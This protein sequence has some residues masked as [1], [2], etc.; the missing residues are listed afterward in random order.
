MIQIGLF[1]YGCVGRGLYKALQQTPQLNATI[2]KIVVKNKLKPRDINH[3]LFAYDKE[4]ILNDREINLVIELIDDADGAFKILTVALQNGKPVISANKKMLANHLEEIL[5]L[6]KKYNL[7][8]LYEAAVAGSIPII[9]SIEEYYNIDTI[10]HINGILNGTTNYIL[11]QCFKE[12]KT[13]ETALKEAQ[14]KGFAE[15]NPTMDIEAFDPTFK[16]IL[17]LAH[18]FGVVVKPEDVLNFG[19]TQLT[20]FDIQFAKE[21]KQTIKLIAQAYQTDKGIAA[22]VLP[23]F[24][25]EQHPL[26]N[27]H[28]E[29]NAVEINGSFNDN[30]LLKGKGA[31]GFPT[32]AAVLADIF[33][34][35]NQYRYPYLKQQLKPVNF[36]N[37]DHLLKI[38]VRYATDEQFEAFHFHQILAR[39]DGNAYR[40]A[41]GYITIKQLI[42]AKLNQGKGAFVAEIEETPIQINS[43]VK[44]PIKNKLPA[45]ESIH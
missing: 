26:Y 20:L 33:A 4:E 23:K 12:A 41:I 35:S 5:L 17:L 3:E 18:A 24:I 39:Y 15:S 11:T 30:Q 9:R 38:Y 16:L 6:Q 21:K 10:T 44:I 29:F 1:G 27:I 32:A 40:Y 7:P 8:V 13:F 45:V 34:L 22:Y 42:Q 31:G 36:I 43:G 25:G 14:L 28:E 19:I 37:N 2:K